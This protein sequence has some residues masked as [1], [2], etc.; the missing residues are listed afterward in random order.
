MPI[1][2]AKGRTAVG[3]DTHVVPAGAV[4]VVQFDG[5][6]Q[7]TL[8]TDP[9]MTVAIWSGGTGGKI[10][11]VLWASQ[12]FIPI[13]IPIPVQ[14]GKNLYVATAA[15]GSYIIVYATADDLSLFS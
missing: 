8:S 15:A 7:A 9:N 10:I 14:E 13:A 2:V 4:A 11:D 6:V 5:P 3:T 12:L 1:I